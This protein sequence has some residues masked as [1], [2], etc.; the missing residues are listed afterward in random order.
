MIAF[1][2]VKPKETP[3]SVFDKEHRTLTFGILL[4]ITLVAFE[5][6]AIVTIAPNIARSLDGLLLYGWI[7]SGQMLASLFSIVL[8]GQWADR[9]GPAKPFLAGVSIFSLG[10]LLAGVAPNML[11]FI[12]GRILQGLGGGAITVALYVAVNLAYN[13]AIR[14]RMIAFM[15]TAW[16]V[17]ALL[18]P[19]AAGY[20]A[21]LFGWRIVFLL[22]LP[23]I[24]IV[25]ALT[26][27]TFLKLERKGEVTEPQ[28]LQALVLVLGAG[29]LLSGLSVS[30]GWLFA[31]MTLGG[32]ALALPSLRFLL[33]KGTLSFQAGLPSVIATRGFLYA[34]FIGV[35]AFL[36]LML[37]SV[38]DL[39]PQVT[40]IAIATAAVSWTVGS[41]VQDR[42]DKRDSSQRPFRIFI[43][44]SAMTLGLGLQLFAL[45]ATSFPLLITLLGWA[46]AGLGI[47]IAHAT[48]TILAFM[49][50]PE[51][52]EGTVSAS[53][54]LA[55]TFIAA[56]S[57]GIGG[58][59]FA[60]ASQRAYSEQ[61]G[62]MLA[63]VFCL[64]LASLS[65][66]SALR[67]RQTKGLAEAR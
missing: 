39:S 20:I 33:P 34:S 57:T 21:E 1:A 59:L 38:H 2:D 17:P 30:R 12:A 23:F 45:Y 44:S 24:V 31:L 51:G 8:S 62:I 48:T 66:V 63:F 5:N 53:L 58:A 54:Q 26:L 25:A 9:L 10:L 46:L 29:I 6:L 4:V 61:T 55:D 13:D 22:I 36:A 64:F 56:L 11:V 52:E 15:S 41:W 42:W 28:W 7:F 14:S 65:V 50:A 37:N 27:K 35:E 47:G 40:G 16:V 18:G 32:A 49:L 43:G 67:I 19:V 60:F 3:A